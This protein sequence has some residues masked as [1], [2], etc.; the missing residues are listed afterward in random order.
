MSLVLGLLGGRDQ[1][2]THEG[3]PMFL[4]PHPPCPAADILP[5]TQMPGEKGSNEKNLPLKEAV[6]FIPA[7]Q[8]H[9]DA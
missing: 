5:F 8:S 9:G 7:L 6:S 2:P 3:V 1:A 4:K